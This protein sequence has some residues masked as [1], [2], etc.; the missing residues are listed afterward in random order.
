[1]RI[2]IHLLRVVVN[3]I[4]RQAIKRLVD[5][6]HHPKANIRMTRRRRLPILTTI[7]TTGPEETTTTALRLPI[8]TTTTTMGREEM[9]ITTTGREE[10]TTTTAVKMTT[11]VPVRAEAWAWGFIS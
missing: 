8:L 6:L 4:I 2:I 10:M 9:T 3:H 11:P 1:M 7:T 5:I